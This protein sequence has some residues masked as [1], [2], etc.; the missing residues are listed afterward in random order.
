MFCFC[1][2]C[3][4]AQNDYNVVQD[5]I[6]VRWKTKGECD[7]R[8]KVWHHSGG[9]GLGTNMTKGKPASVV[10]QSSRGLSCLSGENPQDSSHQSDVLTLQ[11]MYGFKEKAEH[12]RM[13][14][15]SIKERPRKF[16]ERC[17]TKALRHMIH[18]NRNTVQV[19]I[20]FWTNFLLEEG[21]YVSRGLS[22]REGTALRAAWTLAGAADP[23]EH[24]P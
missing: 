7:L 23:P 9:P 8:S 19:S 11:H 17:K 2:N 10:P 1:T 3:L 12:F 13:Q 18:K 16:W 21:E 14:Q 20:K 6:A 24:L 4:T 15:H 5:K 22:P